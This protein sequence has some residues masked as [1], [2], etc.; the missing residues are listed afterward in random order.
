MKNVEKDKQLEEEK[1]CVSEWNGVL[2]KHY[3]DEK[4][5]EVIQPKPN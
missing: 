2:T 1:Y 3:F 5:D 4:P